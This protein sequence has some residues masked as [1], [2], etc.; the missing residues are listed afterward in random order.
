MQGRRHIEEAHSKA[1]KVHS[2]GAEEEARRERKDGTVTRTGREWMLMTKEA[3]HRR[4]TA[5]QNETS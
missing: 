3:R 4:N 2:W 1:H 5:K